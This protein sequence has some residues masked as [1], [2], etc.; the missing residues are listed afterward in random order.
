MAKDCYVQ[1]RQHLMT[2]SV[3]P[4]LWKKMF[5]G[6]SAAKTEATEPTGCQQAFT[7]KRELETTGG[8]VEEVRCEPDDHCDEKAVVPDEVY[9]R[10]DRGA[11]SA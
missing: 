3:S 6:G 9:R 5:V 11:L 2:F 7:G 8:Q 4:E 10:E 1:L